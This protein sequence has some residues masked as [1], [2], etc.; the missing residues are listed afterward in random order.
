M[1]PRNSREC[2]RGGKLK[3]RSVQEVGKEIMMVLQTGVSI[4]RNLGQCSQSWPPVES[5]GR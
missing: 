3:S 4:D 2:R 5:P 1:L